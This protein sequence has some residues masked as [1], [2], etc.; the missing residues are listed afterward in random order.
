[1]PPIFPILKLRVAHPTNDVAVLRKIYV[2]A[3]GLS[4]LYAFVQHDEFDALMVGHPQAPYHF[5]FTSKAGHVAKRAP[6]PKHLFVLHIPRTKRLGSRCSL[7]AG[8]PP[9]ARAG[10]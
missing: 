10:T 6:S 7:A 2:D 8:P 5:E 1:M 3:L 4:E 9:S